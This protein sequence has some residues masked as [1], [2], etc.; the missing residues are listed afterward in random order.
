MRFQAWRSLSDGYRQAVD[1]HSPWSTDTKDPQPIFIDDVATADLTEALRDTVRSE[2]IGSLSFVPLVAN[3][4][5]LGKFMA[6]YDE[7]HRFTSGERE[8][9]V[10]IARQLGFALERLRAEEARREAEEQ[11]RLLLREMNHRVKNILSI[12]GGVVAISARSARSS[13]ELA[14][15]IRERINALMRAH[16]L[17]LPAEGRHDGRATLEELVH[18]IL[19]PYSGASAPGTA[20]SITASG[21]ELTIG[22]SASTTLAL[23]LHELAT[24][25]VKHGSLST[26]TGSV[27][28]E[29]SADGE[30]LLRWTERGGPALDGAPTNI[31]FGSKLLRASI[32]GQMGGRIS[33]DWTPQGLVV[34]LAIPL[35][36]LK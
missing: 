10:T 16:E 15:A 2:G 7:P 30:L 22:G 5:L 34:E 29:W 6:Y 33:Q 14:S 8:L 23:V 31:G 28:I 9:A 25:A 1:G 36:S 32:S 13:D 35:H 27:R 12:A 26:A 18:A 4:D 24:N 17:I 3:G 21:S 11:Q 20:G 19:V